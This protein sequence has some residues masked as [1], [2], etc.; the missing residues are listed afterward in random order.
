MS[1]YLLVFEKACHLSVE[2]EHGAYWAVKKP[3]LDMKLERPQYLLQL[4]ELYEIQNNAYENAKIYKEHTK[5]W[6]DKRIFTREF[7]LR[8]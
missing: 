4:D 7:K 2:L 6:H 5:L 3:N 1:P 8:E